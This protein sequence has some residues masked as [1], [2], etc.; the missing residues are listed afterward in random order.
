MTTNET[1]IAIGKKIASFVRT[2]R[3]LVSVAKYDAQD[4]RHHVLLRT[5]M[6]PPCVLTG[7]TEKRIWSQQEIEE[8]YKINPMFKI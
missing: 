8:F 4:P 2:V 5:L 1:D 3:I 6:R 7:P